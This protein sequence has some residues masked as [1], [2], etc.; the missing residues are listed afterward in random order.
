MYM[1]DTFSYFYIL[2]YGMLSQL[3]PLHLLWVTGAYITP[4]VLYLLMQV[5]LMCCSGQGELA[6]YK[7]CSQSYYLSLYRYITVDTCL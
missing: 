4:K 1:L 6:T 5:H 3:R 2:Y 7:S